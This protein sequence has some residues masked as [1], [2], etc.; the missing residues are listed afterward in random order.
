VPTLA[1]LAVT[2]ANGEALVGSIHRAMNM[3]KMAN[4]FFNGV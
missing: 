1:K 2:Q 4:N 3:P